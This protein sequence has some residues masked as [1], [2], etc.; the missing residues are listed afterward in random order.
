MIN[1]IRSTT[2]QRPMSQIDMGEDE[3]RLRYRYYWWY[4][5]DAPQ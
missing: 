5:F 1:Y 2:I 3:V 4:R